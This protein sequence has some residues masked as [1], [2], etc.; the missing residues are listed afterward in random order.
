MPEIYDP[1]LKARLTV[2]ESDRVRSLDHVDEYWESPEATP[3]E[4]AIAYLR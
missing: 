4:T 2:D 3:R 1:K